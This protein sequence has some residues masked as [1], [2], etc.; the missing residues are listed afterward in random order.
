MLKIYTSIEEALKHVDSSMLPK[1]YGGTMPMA[2]MI[3]NVTI[4]FT[5][6]TF[7]YFYFI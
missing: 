6:T 2:E 1:E 5:S 4:I 3:G 7:F